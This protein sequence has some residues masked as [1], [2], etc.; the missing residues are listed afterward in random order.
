M[1][2]SSIN[3]HAKPKIENANFRGK[4]SP[5]E[6]FNKYL[7][8]EE[9]RKHPEITPAIKGD[10]KFRLDILSRQKLKII[11]IK[12][13][14]NQ[15]RLKFISRLNSFHKLYFD[16]YKNTINSKDE[17]NALNQENRLFSQKYKNSKINKN[18]D[19]F[20]D[21]KAQY[22]K[23]NYY[24]SPM[25]GNKNIFNG[26]ILLS[27][28]DELKNYIVYDLGTP[29]SNIKSL[30]FL[31]KINAKL[32]DKTSEKELKVINH[33]LDLISL[34]MDK[35]QKDQK[36]EIQKTQKDILNVKETINSID[37][38]NYFYDMDTKQYLDTLKKE[39]SRGTS[40]KISTR[41][42]SALN[43]LDNAKYQNIINNNS[44]N[45]KLFHIK[46]DEKK[47]KKKINHIKRNRNL[48]NLITQ[49]ENDKND[50]NKSK[51]Y[52]YND[53]EY[54]KT[55]DNNN[56]SKSPLEKLY[57]NISK[58]DDLLNYQ[59][60]IKKYLINKKY[61]ICVKINPTSI[62]NNFENAREKIYESEFLKNDYQLRKQIGG[63]LKDAEKKNND[64][65]KI[66]NK[67]DNIE[68]KIIKLFCDINNPR[69]K[70]DLN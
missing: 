31:H 59:K 68:D 69:K 52:I 29:F 41:V 44:I 15:N 13:I 25:D 56:L 16:S 19:K 47:S 33:K 36:N 61:D 9:I 17:I 2:S 38:M 49:N 6:I 35:I 66:K 63:N 67:M 55:L 4:Y 60:D 11:N 30:S 22:E 37:D 62:C 23:R 8:I 14:Q 27:S 5:G 1:S 64:D 46:N 18:M 3:I 26:N 28:R 45:K 51:Q 42:N 21:I 70:E 20:N 43:C 65:L 57:D 40:A 53:R 39:S 58:K 10:K 24:V 34:G 54:V 50:K 48:Y 32:G 7:T 12:G